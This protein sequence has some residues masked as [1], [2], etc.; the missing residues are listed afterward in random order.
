MSDINER[1]RSV[2]SRLEECQMVLA[3]VGERDTAQLVAMA[4]LQLRMRLHHIGDAELKALCDAM[5]PKPDDSA[6]VSKA[7]DRGS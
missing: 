2:M 1:L 4:I 3:D 7:S 6:D 5:M